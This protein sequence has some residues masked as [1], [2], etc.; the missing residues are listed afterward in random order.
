MKK[1]N[2]KQKLKLAYIK[3]RNI[4]KIVKKNFAGII[5]KIILWATASI[6][7]LCFCANISNRIPVLDYMVREMK[8][9]KAYN[10]TGNI[11]IGD[12]NISKINEISVCIGAYKIYINNGQEFSLNFSGIINEDIPVVITYIYDGIEKQEIK[13]ISYKKH[14]A[15]IQV[16]WKIEI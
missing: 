1:Y 7:I 13:Y 4:L 5:G 3:I 2:I 14:Q 16:N 9:P 15:K 10:V 12:S 6:F 8:M 11:E